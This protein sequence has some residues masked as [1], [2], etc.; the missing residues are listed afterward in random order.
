[1]QD[2][3]LVTVDFHGQQLEAT[4][5]NGQP[6]VAM[7]PICENIGIDWEAQRQRIAR[8]PVLNSTACMTQ[9]FAEDGKQ[10]EMLCLPLSMLNGWLFGVDVN[11][12]R[13]DVQPKLIRYQLECFDVLHRHFMQPSVPSDLYGRIL[14][15]EKD[16][17]ASRAL[18]SVAGRALSLRRK[19]KKVLGQI[20]ELLREEVQLKLLL[21]KI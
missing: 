20:V 4:L 14:K 18:A 9:V 16:E 11:R 10:R 15:A 5:H 7:K 8:H 13:P 17:A 1:M 6:Y 21:T 19:E 3:Q 12:V 2:H